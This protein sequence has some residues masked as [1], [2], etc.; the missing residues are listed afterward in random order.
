MPIKLL[1]TTGDSWTY[2]EELGDVTAVDNLN[3][4][5]YNSWPW[6]VSQHYNI[7]QLIND[8]RGGGSN[9][10]MYR[11][12]IEFLQ[13]YKGK[14]SELAISGCPSIEPSQFL[15]RDLG[16]TLQKSSTDQELFVKAKV[17]NIGPKDS[18]YV[19]VLWINNS[20]EMSQ[21]VLVPAG[22]SADIY[23]EWPAKPGLHQIRVDRLQ[24]E[25]QIMPLL[26]SQAGNQSPLLL[27]LIYTAVAL[28]SIGLGILGLWFVMARK[29]KL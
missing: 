2:G 25:I 14:F 29:A 13:S 26:S 1:Y 21:T 27:I 6:H 18:N 23:F 17:E 7:P 15:T 9:A 11:R 16:F 22:E 3:H 12:T 10:R 24:G 8:A 20:S 28:G 19:A 4:K 5:F